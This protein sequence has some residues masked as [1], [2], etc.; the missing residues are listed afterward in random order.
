M[1]KLI[2]SLLLLIIILACKK[3]PDAHPDPQNLHIGFWHNP[4]LAD[5]IWTFQRI[6]TFPENDY[7]FVMVRGGLFIERKNAGFC[8]TP[9][10]T[11]ADYEGNWEK[12][13][14]ILTINTKSWAGSLQYIWRIKHN[15]NNTLSVV[16]LQ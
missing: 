15:D 12:S 16:K 13:G 9:P 3:T 8:G 10:I 11:Y 6:Y 2:I 7:G 4:Q 5:S 14:Q 1:N